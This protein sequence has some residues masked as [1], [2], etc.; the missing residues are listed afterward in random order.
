MIDRKKPVSFHFNGKQYQGYEGDTLASALIANGVSV[1][2]RSFKYH[3]PRG[4]VG[5][6][7]EEPASLVELEGE[8]A[9]GNNPI[10]TVQ[11]QGGLRANSVNCWPS[12]DYDFGGINQLFTKF[13][14]AGFYYK[15][16]KWP[17]WHLFER[18]IRRAAGLAGA[19]AN[20]PSQ[21]RFEARNA[22]TDVLIAGAG[23]AG[24]MAALTAG[25]AG[26]RVILVDESTKA[27]GSLLNRTLEID[28]L[29][30]TEWVSKVVAELDAM[31]NVTHLQNATV[32]AYREHNM[33][34]VNERSP[35]QDGV[36]E[37]SWRIRAGHVI[38]AT[39]AIER[40]L[41][42]ANNDRPGVMMTSAIQAYVNRYAVRPGKRAVLFTN[43]NSSYAV[44]ADMAKAGIEIAAIVDSRASVPAEALAL[45]KG[46][47]VLEGTVV[48]NVKGHK[49]VKSVTVEPKN[50]GT[51]QSISCDLLG[52]SGG[53]NP[54]VHLFSQSRGTLKY[55]KEISTF[56]PD[57]PVEATLSAGAAAGV[58]TLQSALK[59]GSMAGVEAA[60][61][62]GFA[63]VSGDIPDCNDLAYAIEPLWRV[64]NA[65]SKGKA[66]L[67][68]QNDVSVDDVHLALREGYTNV[69]HVKR[70]TT[71][72]MGI[73]QGKVGNINII[74]TVALQTGV[75]PQEV[76]TTTFR[77]PYTPVSFGAIGGLR[78][79][80]VVF[81]YRHTPITEWNHDHGAFMY[82]AG[83]RWRRPGY[84]PRN[85]ETFQET[86]NR[87]CLVVREGVGVYDGSP[88]G[89]FELKGRD[90]G[91]F[92]DFIYTNMMSNLKPG[93]GRYGLMLS[94]DG[95]ILDDGVTFRVDENRWIL[96]TSTGHADAM[97]QHME[98]LLQ[99]E[100]PDW[101][102]KITSVTSQWNNATICGPKARQLLELLGTDFDI[103]PEAF[104]FMS[105]RDGTVA[106]IPARVVRVSFTGELSFEI[107]VAPRHMHELWQKVMETG[108]PLGIEPVGSE[109]SHVL[110]VEKG[111]LSLGHEVDGTV[112]AHDLGMGWVMSKKKPDYLGKRSVELRRAGGS[113]R[114]ELVGLLPVD[115]NRAIP[116][117]AP[118]TPQGRKE[119][120]EGLTT[121]CVWSVA[122][123]RWVALALL[124]NGHSRHGE[125]VHVRL[126]DEIIPAIVTAPV[127]YDPAGEKLRS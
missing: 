94:D 79:E 27:G 75:N 69:E 14:P 86:V 20:P 9:S 113:V 49:R 55:N 2:A 52:Q 10:T 28:G 109:A 80:S 96:S 64:E 1:T 93:N 101:E 57:T 74:G 114:Q 110:R 106:G 108:K 107:N 120:T 78:E 122:N 116:E 53:W 73:D 38:C 83:A 34:I 88:L 48:T 40:A 97:N 92:L 50:G 37:R 77:S 19:P 87:E 35:D 65:S 7:V 56:E 126:L 4:I 54:A 66:F 17:N 127:H 102:V 3:R 104:K 123:N 47:K 67:D 81:P 124:K 33:I 30:A 44:A 125:T 13:I 95:L 60:Q 98:E 43:N 42:F 82:E 36:L 6:G 63:A 46:I 12:V 89:T 91:K 31:D 62:S 112:D 70:Y 115:P 103:S 24:L 111:F 29:P 25:R 45:V 41:V 23:A 84:F 8:F 16:F 5:L 105:F 72:G 22:H 58:M 71:G 99:T 15:T 61:N 59:T 32:W 51:S 90:V 117:G 100:Y 119:A 76:G 85:S 121:A 11:I 39:G 68:I 21:G 18:S 118:L 26:A